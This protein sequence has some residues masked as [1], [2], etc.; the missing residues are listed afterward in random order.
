M[1]YLHEIIKSDMS[2][3]GKNFSSRFRIKSGDKIL[4]L[5]K[6]CVMGI[7]N[8]TPDSFYDGGKY[9]KGKRYLHHVEQ[10]IEEGAMIIDL[11][12][13]ST[14]PG[15]MQVDESVEKRRL[16][17][18]L[19]EIRKEFPDIFIS[20]DTFRA[21]VAS[22][23]IG[24]G[25]DMINDISG[26]RFDDGMLNTVADKKVPYIIMHIQ[27]TPEKMQVNPVYHDVTW[28]LLN[29]FTE[30]ISAA[31]DAGI[32]QLIIDPGFGFGKTVRHNYQILKDIKSFSKFDIP[33][34]A[35]IS[36]KSM[37]NRVINT[38]PEDALYGTVVLNTIAI[39]N[40]ANILR[41]HDVKPAV[42]LIR[43]CEQYIE[44]PA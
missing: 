28:E 18:V 33:V 3:K 35:G 20:V 36:R 23:T 34:S 32:S 10:M 5:G 7:L 44:N 17:P 39:L 31:H 22:E 30:R 27:G 41:V 11:G 14:R 19:S 25:A 43:L 2:G 8:L 13:V 15:A 29:Y 12:A 9:L 40:G 6:P 4:D 21:S 42:E 38:D 26:G 16:L 24:A 1:L 37:I